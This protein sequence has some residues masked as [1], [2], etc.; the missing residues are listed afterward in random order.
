MVEAKHGSSLIDPCGWRA[1]VN[2]SVHGHISLSHRLWIANTYI[3]LIKH[4]KELTQIVQWLL[5]Y[6]S[7]ISTHFRLHVYPCYPDEV[8]VST[9]QLAMVLSY[10]GWYVNDAWNRKTKRVWHNHVDLLFLPCY[11]DQ[12]AFSRACF[13][14]QLSK[15]VVSILILELVTRTNNCGTSIAHHS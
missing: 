8:A 13:L 11:L 14:W 3:T 6:S 15:W 9:P 12:G 10:C 2:L 7:A 4:C 5:L 1:E